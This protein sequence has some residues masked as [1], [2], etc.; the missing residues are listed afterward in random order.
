V[1]KVTIL[2]ERGEKVFSDSDENAGGELGHGAKL[3]EGREDEA[4]ASCSLF[5]R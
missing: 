2:N 3:I 1:V 5:S 4:A